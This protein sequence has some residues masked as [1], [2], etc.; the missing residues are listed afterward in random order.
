MAIFGLADNLIHDNIIVNAGKMGIFCD[1][2]TEPGAG[3]KIIN[4][5]IINPKTEG[6]RIYSE[7]V[8][9]NTIMNNIIVNA[10]SYSAY[11]DGSYI[12]KL[13]GVNLDMSNNYTTQDIS[14]L[15]FVNPATFNYRLTDESPVIDIGK[16]ISTYGIFKDFYGANRLRGATYDIG[17]SE[18]Y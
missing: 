13:Y 15:K 18:N 2:R 5:T 4:N 16:N 11:A 14:D 3:Y 8:P 7:H 10:G 6:M 17:A 1:E 12:M 9:V